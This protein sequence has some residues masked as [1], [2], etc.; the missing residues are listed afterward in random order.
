MEGRVTFIIAHRL[1]T[2][3]KADR[4][5]VVDHGEIVEQGGHDE[6]IARGGL[7]AALYRQQ[8][9]I[10]THAVGEASTNGA[11]TVRGALRHLLGGRVR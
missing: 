3:R 9:N 6:L 4:I 1:S 8:M 11:R 2:I 5:L 7:Y 10:A